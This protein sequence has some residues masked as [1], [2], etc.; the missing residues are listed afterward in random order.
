ML[1]SN[2]TH[3][4]LLNMKTDPKK[5]FPIGTSKQELWSKEPGCTERRKSGCS[6]EPEHKIFYVSVCFFVLLLAFFSS[7]HKESG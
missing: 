2:D 4:N 6:D 5:W 7:S 1:A 3:L